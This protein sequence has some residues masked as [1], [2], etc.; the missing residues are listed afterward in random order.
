VRL[1][2]LSTSKKDQQGF[3]L[4]ELIVYTLISSMLLT[5]VASV[6]ISLYSVQEDVLQ[7]GK[8]AGE[9][10]LVAASINYGVR[11]STA[12]SLSETAAG[13]LLLAETLTGA[14]EAGTVCQ[15]WWFDGEGMSMYASSG[16]TRE[17]LPTTSSTSGWML[18]SDSIDALEEAPL[19]AQIGN[20]VEFSMKSTNAQGIVTE[21]RSRIS[22]RGQYSES[23][24]CF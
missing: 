4:I 18:L 24:T 12:V 9:L 1:Q 7:S 13:Q 3:S 15:A 19:F 20:T 16:P 14:D 2:L 11:N 17:S 5:V 6:F 22:G 10:Q 23:S 8:S 21:I